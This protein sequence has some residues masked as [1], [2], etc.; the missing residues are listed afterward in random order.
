MPVEAVA[1][2]IAS[3]DI[4][5][6]PHGQHNKDHHACQFISVGGVPDHQEHSSEGPWVAMPQASQPG[7][8]IGDPDRQT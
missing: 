3:L 7:E 1:L 8:T 2:G 5:E 4:S 6:S